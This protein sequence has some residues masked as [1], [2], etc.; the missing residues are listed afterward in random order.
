RGERQR[1]HGGDAHQEDLT[2]SCD[3][4]HSGPCHRR[5]EGGKGRVRMRIRDSGGKVRVSEGRIKRAY[6]LAASGTPPS[7]RR[8]EGRSSRIS[9][10]TACFS[11]TR[12]A[13]SS[14][15]VRSCA[16]PSR[17]VRNRACS[18][19]PRVADSSNALTCSAINP[20]C[21]FSSPTRGE[22]M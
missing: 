21:G 18:P 14:T 15:C 11:L 10:A 7:H 16:T 4:D 19:P 22:Q 2:R 12:V 20:N 13:E 8:Q 3:P 17:I 5:D 6:V 1:D 9:P